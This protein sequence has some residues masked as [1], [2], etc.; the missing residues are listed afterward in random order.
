VDVDETAKRR[1]THDVDQDFAMDKQYNCG[2][3]VE[4]G[5]E[6]LGM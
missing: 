4:I 3:N 1:P 6:I 5:K 2:V